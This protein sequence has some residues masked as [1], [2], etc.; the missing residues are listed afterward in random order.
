MKRSLLKSSPVITGTEIKDSPLKGKFFKDKG[1]E[2][3]SVTHNSY[4]YEV[5][6][7]VTKVFEKEVLLN[8]IQFSS[9]GNVCFVKDFSYPKADLEKPQKDELGTVKRITKATYNKKVLIGGK[10]TKHILAK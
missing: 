7:H 9:D 3:F 8:G 4:D 5:Y 1:R 6:V 2:E 10:L